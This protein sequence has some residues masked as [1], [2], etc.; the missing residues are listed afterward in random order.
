MISGKQHR[1]SKAADIYREHMEYSDMV[2]DVSQADSLQDVFQRLN[3]HSYM[4]YNLKRLYLFI[5]GDYMDALEHGQKQQFRLSGSTMLHT[6][7]MRN[8]DYS[9]RFDGAVFQ[10]DQILHLLGEEIGKPRAYYLSPLH[11][12]EQF[13]GIASLSFGKKLFQF[14][15]TYMEYIRNLNTALDRLLHESAYRRQ[16]A[17]YQKDARTNIYSFAGFCEWLSSCDMQGRMFVCAEISDIKRLYGKYGGKQTHMMVQEFGSQIS[18]LLLP[19]EACGYIAQDCI[20]MLLRS[21]ERIDALFAELKKRLRSSAWSFSFSFGSCPITDRHLPMPDGIYDLIAEAGNHTLHTYQ[22]QSRGNRALYEKLCRLRRDLQLHPGQ[23]WTI[24]SISEQ[25]HVS[26]SCL[27]K[28]Y[29]E[30]FGRSVMDE[31]IEFR[32]SL[33]KRLLLETDLTVTDIAAQ[34]G[35]SAGSYFMKQFKQIESVT[36]T[37]YRQKA[38]SHA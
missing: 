37:E 5:S 34:C 1:E 33:A 15:T 8:G 29:K 13:F 32:I 10:A 12:D 23:A 35:Y 28:N 9:A 18:D 22:T 3:F 6:V 14:D 20:G 2:F 16:I 30:Y 26:K 19:D 27:Q 4:L 38:G 36:P 25:L 24:D 17:A 7:Y 11:S 31:L 21:E